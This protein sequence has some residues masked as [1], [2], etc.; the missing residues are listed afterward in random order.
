MRSGGKMKAFESKFYAVAENSSLPPDQQLAGKIFL[1][2]KGYSA[3]FKSTS[4]L[5]PGLSQP[6]LLVRTG[7]PE[8][9]VWNDRLNFK[10]NQGGETL[11]LRVIC[12][13]ADLI[14]K[15]KED[16]LVAWLDRLTGSE[17]D[18]V[19]AL[20]DEAGIK[21][22]REEDIRTFC[23]LK[24]PQL[25]QLAMNLEKEG[26]IYILSF[27][28]LFILSQR[29]FSFLVKKIYDYIESYHR[30]RPQEQGVP[31]KKIQDRFSLPRQILLLALKRLA[32]DGQVTLTKD[33]AALSSFET[34]VSAE[35]AEVM[36]A[37]E[38]LLRQEKFSLASFDELA[39]KFK[40]HPS[41]LN[42]LLDLLLRQKKIVKSQEGFWI[43]SDWLN[44][45]K[46]QLS[47]LKASGRRDLTVGE[48]KRLTGLSR[49]YAIPLL[50][51]LDELGLTRR[52]GNK[53]LIL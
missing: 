10:P 40:I 25:L 46:T 49:K 42:T 13:A 39:Q 11:E 22:L 31:L 27:S 15:Q 43:H 17:E 5:S 53:R 18:L 21:G 44:S 6:Y 8:T 26:Q 45:L 14:K 7:L 50:E 30:K 16:K 41:R 2:K 4:A 29:S 23:R 38:N 33:L 52:I 20:A 24:P 19:M 3:T 9:L 28:P 36:K 34:R 51:F 32:K 35:E 37:V 1:G 47:E 48:F 12:P